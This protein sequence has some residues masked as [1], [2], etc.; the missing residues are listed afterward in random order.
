M[1]ESEKENLE[2]KDN[3]FGQPFQGDYENEI[4]E[5]QYLEAPETEIGR[6]TS[7]NAKLK[8]DLLQAK[9]ANIRVWTLVAVV[10]TVFGI[11]LFMWLGVFPKYKWIS[12]TNN[13][14]ICEIAA[15][16]HAPIAPATLTSYALET[17]VNSYTYDYVNYRESITKTG[18]AYYTDRGR[19]SYYKSMDE[20]G[21]LKKVIDGRFILKA[22]PFASPVI[23]TQGNR[24]SNRTWVIQVPIAIDFY[25]GN[26][27]K[28]QSSQKF[29]AEVTLIQMPASKDNLKGL[30]SDNVILK[31]YL[32]N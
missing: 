4:L 12:T 22:Y 16:D 7:E 9:R 27:G 15:V 2:E 1:S 8:L 11:A 25:T 30:A 14:A 20:S 24:G 19:E 28:P 23:T 10:A 5:E 6:V 13:N 26:L 3:E 32:G 31:P 21:N 18:N 29:I 17:V